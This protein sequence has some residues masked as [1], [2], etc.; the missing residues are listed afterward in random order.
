MTKRI[1]TPQHTLQVEYNKNGDAK[2]RVFFERLP[3]DYGYKTIVKKNPFTLF[4]LI[5]RDTFE[6]RYKK[7]YD[8]AVLLRERYLDDAEEKFKKQRDGDGWHGVGWYSNGGGR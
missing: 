1:T 3:R 8:K 7:A 5:K 2:I 6:N 4:G